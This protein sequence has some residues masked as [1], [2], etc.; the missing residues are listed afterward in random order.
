MEQQTIRILIVDDDMEDFMIIRDLLAEISV[1]KYLPEWKNN[2]RSA[3]EAIQTVPYDVYLFDYQL[4]VHNG[5]E[6]LQEISR[7]D[8]RKPVIF[9]TGMQDH[10]IDLEAMHLGA[11]D[12][13]IKNGLTAHLLEKSIRYAIERKKIETELFREKEQAIVTLE[14]IGDMVVITDNNGDITHLNKTA[15]NILGWQTPEIEGQSF[16]AV[17]KLVN[18]TTRAPIDDPLRMVAEQNSMWVLPVPTILINREGREF[19]VEGSFSPIHNHQNQITGLVTVFHDVTENREL[20]KKISYQASHDFLTGLDNRMKFEEKLELLLA[21]TTGQQE[22]ALLYLDL[23][24]FKIINDTCG[25]FAGDQLL[26]QISSTIRQI[27][28]QS[29]TVARLGGDEFGVLLENCP[30]YK[31]TEIATKICEAAAQLRFIWKDKTFS[32]GVSIGVVIIS[33]QNRDMATIL[34]SADQACYI[35]KKE[36]GGRFH[37]SEGS[38][39]NGGLEETQ[40]LS[41][42]IKAFEE[43][44]FILTFQPFVPLSGESQANPS[45]NCFE[46]LIRMKDGSGNLIYPSHFLPVIQRQKMMPAIDQ[47]VINEFFSLYDRFLADHI[48][49][50]PWMFSINISGASF[51]YESFWEFVREQF[52]KYQIPPEIICFEITETAA[53]SNFNSAMQWIRNLKSM[54]CRLAIDDFGSGLTS[55]HYLRYLPI[56]Y[57]KIDGS[58]IKN[59]NN[60]IID[61]TMASAIN[62]LAHLMEM[63]TIAEFVED[64]AIYDKLKATGVDYAQGYFISKPMFLE[65]LMEKME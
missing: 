5:L 19:A 6:L 10:E 61:A 54:G 42:I 63:K 45:W 65:E 35:A 15:E 33:F 30:A 37:L 24:H 21:K 4:G 64:Q 11:S 26:K 36:G 14:S 39:A 46:V 59:I 17:I 25:H 38:G 50:K 23:D 44:R 62:Q 27:L 29:D 34:A 13:L 56:D 48:P 1:T 2:Y 43:E 28:R 20:A 47:W 18:E 40:W 16:F 55:F 60:D 9:F 8:S 7:L 12:Y 41:T 58:I 3:L 32:F 52:A 22:H 49:N 53:V 57:I 31:A 51:D